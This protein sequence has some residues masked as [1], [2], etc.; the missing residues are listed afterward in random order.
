MLGGGAG[1]ESQ[2]RAGSDQHEGA[3]P[4]PKSGSVPGG[5]R[6]WVL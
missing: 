4:E 3:W 1:V 6:G 5:R 2:E